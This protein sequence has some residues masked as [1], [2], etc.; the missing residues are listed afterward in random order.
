MDNS[1]LEKELAK[2]RLQLDSKEEEAATLKENLELCDKQIGLLH[3]IKDAEL[4]ELRTKE[5]LASEENEDL[6]TA[7]NLLQAKVSELQLQLD[8]SRKVAV[9]FEE[10]AQ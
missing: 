3:F 9:D 7:S 4:Q 8:T 1:N 2:M 5:K 6:K 10:K